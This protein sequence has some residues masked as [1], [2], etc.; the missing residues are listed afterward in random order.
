MA[1]RYYKVA[2]IQELRPGR[3]KLV[4]V[5]HQQLVLCNVGGSFYAIEN[6]CSHDGGPLGEGNLQGTRIECPRH[7]AKFDVTTGEALIFPALAPVT[8]FAVRVDGD[9]IEVGIEE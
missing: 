7:G 3:M 2:T 8:T 1:V 6:M 5:N 4:A 9:S